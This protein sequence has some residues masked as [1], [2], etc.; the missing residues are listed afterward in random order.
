MV[1]TLITKTEQARK[2]REK[3]E[4]I[5]REKRAIE[6]QD[7]LEQ[8][9][10][11]GSIHCYFEVT[12]LR[13]NYKAD[14]I[15]TTKGAEVPVIEAK[16]LYRAMKAGLNIIG[17]RVGHF[18]VRSIDET[19][20]TVGC[21]VIPLSEIE[22]IAPAVMAYHITPKVCEDCL[23]IDGHEANCATQTEVQG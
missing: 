10:A 19:N 22:R 7:K 6:E 2:E 13:V 18:E 12:R 23:G 11:G 20:L 5:A 9:L 4:K 16:K 3:Q 17:Q 21:H 1:K 14:T 15:E 8:W